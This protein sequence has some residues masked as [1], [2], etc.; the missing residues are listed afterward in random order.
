MYLVTGATGLLGSHIVCSLLAS[1]QKV[2][3][4]KRAN[5]SLIWFHKIAKAQEISDALV[6]SIQWVEGDILDV[7]SLEQAVKDIDFVIH[8]AAKVSFRKK[9]R[10]LLFKTNVEGTANVVNACLGTSVKKLC[11]ISSIA[12]LSRNLDGDEIT[13][14]SEW[15]DSTENSQYALSKYRGELEVWRGVEEGLPAVVLNPGFVL[16]FGDPKTSSASIFWKLKKGL[17]FYSN[18]VNGFVDVQD[19]ANAALLLTPKMEVINERFVLVGHNSAYGDLF[20]MIAA[21]LNSPKPSFL[22]GRKTA[23]IAIWVLKI[24]HFIGIRPS[25]ITPETLRTA[26]G[27]FYYSSA[28]IRRLANFEFTPLDQTIATTCTRFNKYGFI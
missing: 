3:A 7:V 17:K 24:L 11:Y 19:V 20:F 21:Q 13:E 10:E 15:Q 26:T 4:L 25:F 16:G 14:D 12:A 28:K 23:K 8:S 22:I 5:S 18:G 1:G 2:R 9:D 6:D 27:K